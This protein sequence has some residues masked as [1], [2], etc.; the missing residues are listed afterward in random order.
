ML[1]AMSF[2]IV[3]KLRMIQVSIIQGLGAAIHTKNNRA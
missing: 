2:T 3:K 1:T